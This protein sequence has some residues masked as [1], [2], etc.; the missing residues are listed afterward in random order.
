MARTVRRAQAVTSSQPASRMQSQ[1]CSVSQAAQVARGAGSNV[2]SVAEDEAMRCLILIRNF[3]EGYQQARAAAAAA[4]V[5]SARATMPPALTA[6]V[7]VHVVSGVLHTQL[8]AS[9]HAR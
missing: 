7:P 5:C 9:P 1:S 3:V 4:L 8:P 2:E 6:S